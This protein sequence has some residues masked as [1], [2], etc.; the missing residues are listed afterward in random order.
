MMECKPMRGDIYFAD[1]PS[2]AEHEQFGFR[3]VVILQNDVGNKFSPTTIVAPL[4]SKTKKR[5][6]P[7]HFLIH[8]DS[9]NGLH[10]DSVALLEQIRTIPQ[11]V[12]VNK[13]GEIDPSSIEPALKAS[14]GLN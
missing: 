8:A 10:R 13:I 1:L 7:T 4:T 14:L 9:E 11:S 2:A 12:L 6:Q 3:P 5:N